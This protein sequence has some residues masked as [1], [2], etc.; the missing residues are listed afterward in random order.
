MT[1]TAAWAMVTASQYILG[2]RPDFDGLRIEP[3]L[4]PP[5]P[6]IPRCVCFVARPYEIEVEKPV[7][8]CT[9][10]REVCVSGQRVEGNLVLVAE[11]GETVHVQVRMG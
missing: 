4:P 2:I 1:G 3:R 5:G 11:A 9:G 8:V 6:A 7:G 10:V